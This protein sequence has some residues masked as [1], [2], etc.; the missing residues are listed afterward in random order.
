VR[1]RRQ[2]RARFVSNGTIAGVIDRVTLQGKRIKPK[3]PASQLF[4]ET[5]T[6]SKDFGACQPTM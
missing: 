2:E 1:K 4:W 3:V 5:K 6:I